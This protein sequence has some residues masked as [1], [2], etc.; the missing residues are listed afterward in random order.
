MR[1]R[2]QLAQTC[3]IVGRFAFSGLEHLALCL[4]V[5]GVT[6]TSQFQPRGLHYRVALPTDVARQLILIAEG[7]QHMA[8][9]RQRLDSQFLGVAEPHMPPRCHPNCQ[10]HNEQQGD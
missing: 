9:S 6:V 2:L 8:G 5:Y 1:A 10:S 4:D 7:E 3:H